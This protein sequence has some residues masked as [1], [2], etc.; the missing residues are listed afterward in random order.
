MRP[1]N[2]VLAERENFRIMG[3][4]LIT[5]DTVKPEPEG[6]IVLIPFVIKEYVPNRHGSL[7]VH[8]IGINKD[9]VNTGWDETNVGLYNSSIL[10]IE[11]DEFKELFK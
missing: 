9:F 5:R 2:S 10:V 1:I 6:T 3:P 7:M 4:G 11:P 8:L